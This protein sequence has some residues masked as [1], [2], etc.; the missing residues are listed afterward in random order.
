MNMEEERDDHRSTARKYV[1]L[2]IYDIISNKQRVKMAKLLSSYGTR[3][4]KS[5]FEAR[6]TRKQFAK[7]NADIKRILKPDD[8]IRIYKL[9]DYEEIITYGSKEYE[10]FED[11][12]II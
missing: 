11:V 1:I 3:V 7:L 8:N 5:A 4:Q 9:Y 2:V 10:Q 6:L 12:I